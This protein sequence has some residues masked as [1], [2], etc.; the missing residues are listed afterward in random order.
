[1]NINYAD[2]NECCNEMLSIVTRMNNLID[3]IKDQ[4]DSLQNGI[5]SGPAAD[6]YCEKFRNLINGF[7]SISNQ[8]K[9]EVSKINQCME[10]YKK[11]DNVIMGGKPKKHQMLE[12]SVW[13]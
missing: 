12:F 7:D 3:N 5:W 1:M 4:A 11:L 9:Y 8:I 13:E 2:V 10:N 6:N